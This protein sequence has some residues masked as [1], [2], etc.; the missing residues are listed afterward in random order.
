MFDMLLVKVVAKQHWSLIRT[1]RWKLPCTVPMASTGGESAYLPKLLTFSV[2]LDEIRPWLLVSR[3][4][5]LADEN[6]NR[7]SKFLSQDRLL[8]LSISDS[9]VWCW[10]KRSGEHVKQLE[11]KT[12][13]QKYLQY[14]PTSPPLF[15]Q[16]QF[17]FSESSCHHFL[18]LQKFAQY[19]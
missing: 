3:K 17:F 9:E 8:D 15:E 12:T 2:W 11:T 14:L 16:W 13:S 4:I 7:V 5:L 10:T 19:N 1:P 18:S 6:C